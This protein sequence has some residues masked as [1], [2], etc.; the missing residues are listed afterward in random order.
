MKTLRE[1]L[2]RFVFCALLLPAMAVAQD[3]A[4]TLR[5]GW[6]S[7]GSVESQTVLLDV[8]R[9]GLRDVGYVEGK[10]LVIEKRWADGKPERLPQLA[11]ELAAA[12]VVAIVTVFTATAVEAKQAVSDVPILFT[13]VSDPVHAGLVKDLARPG[14]N[15]TGFASLNIQLAPKRLEIL[16]EILPAAKK[17]AFFYSSG[18]ETDRGKLEATV[19]AAGKMGLQVVPVDVQRVAFAEAF[20]AAAASG[21]KAAIVV[22]NGSS[23]DARREIVGLA[24]KHRMPAIYEAPPF[25]TEGGFLSYSVSQYAQIGRAAVY[26]DKLSKGAKVGDLPVE[27]AATLE[28]VINVTHAKELGIRVPES[29]MLRA[30]R[31]I[32]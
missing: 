17:V 12:K 11:K 18:L 24:A 27:Q 20:K 29:I 32:E 30:T 4:K 19:Q 3:S 22:L 25:V 16:H 14:G 10:N 1:I 31:V 21:A 26:L 7:P 8:L 28:M 2:V 5:V 13:M 23:F 9:A 6:L 15:V